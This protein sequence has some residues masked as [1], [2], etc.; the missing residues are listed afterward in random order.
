M[1]LI[2]TVVSD[3]IYNIIYGV[4]AQ[5]DGNHQTYRI[6]LQWIVRQHDAVGWNGLTSLTTGTSGGL[7]LTR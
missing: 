6:L 4:Y 5:R 2:N 7:L 1:V 3:G